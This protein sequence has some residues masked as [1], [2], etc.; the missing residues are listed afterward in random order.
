MPRFQYPCPGCRTTNSLHQQ[1]CSFEGAD[2]SAIEK[3]YTDLLAVLSD[4]DAA[5]LSEAALR[6]AVHGEWGGLYKAALGVL[7]HEGRVVEDDGRLRL[8][9]AAEYKEQVSEPDR[10][11]LRT[12]YEHGS[13]P[14][15]H[16]NAVFAMI[17]WYEMVGLSWAETKE[18]VVE[19][20]RTSGAWDRGGFEESSPEELVE[21]KRHVYDAGY[22]WKEKAQAAKRVIERHR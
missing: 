5:P 16:D 7:R 13:V 3:A 1:G 21:S 12:I 11:P 15:C 22:G 4:P 10:E 14:G 19:W 17:A 9:T 20:L 18:N 2:W 6:E 8:L